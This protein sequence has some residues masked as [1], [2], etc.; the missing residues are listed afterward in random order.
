MVSVISSCLTLAGVSLTM[1]FRTLA[2][3]RHVEPIVSMAR[4]WSATAAM[5]SKRCVESHIVSLPS[6]EERA[7]IPLQ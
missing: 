5:D 6:A 2:Q 3:V 7:E 1:S 4:G